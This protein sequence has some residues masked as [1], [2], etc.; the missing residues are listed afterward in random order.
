MSGFVVQGPKSDYRDNSGLKNRL[1]PL[2]FN[3]WHMSNF[4][5]IRSFPVLTGMGG[6]IF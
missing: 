4:C 6:K 5:I 3:Q 2:E 1:F